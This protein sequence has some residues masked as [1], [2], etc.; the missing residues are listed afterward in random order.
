[1]ILSPSLTPCRITDV[2]LTLD[3]DTVTI[4]RHGKS[5]AFRIN[6]AAAY[7][8]QLCD[9]IKN[10]SQITGIVFELDTLPGDEVDRYVSDTISELFSRDLL[11][12]KSKD[13][14][15]FANIAFTD[16]QGELSH[17]DYFLANLMGEWFDLKVSPIDEA[18]IYVNAGNPGAF[19]EQAP[20]R[21]FVSE[22]G[23]VP[24]D[25][26]DFFFT[27]ERNA[28]IP[29]DKNLLLPVNA[30][31]DPVAKLLPEDYFKIVN[32]LGGHEDGHGSPPA[33]VSGPEA[34][35]GIIK[36]KLT[37][38]MATFDDY[39]GV[40]FSVQAIRMY[41]PEVTEETEILIIDNN[42]TGV[43][44]S[45][46]QN[47]S[48]Q[49]PGCRYL[50]VDDIRGTAVRDFVF[51]EASTDYVMCMDSHVFI[52]P[53]AI[54]K[55]IDY[56]D[57][58]PG[59]PDLLQGPLINDNLQEIN[60]HFEPAWREG[61]YGFW[62]CDER[63]VD[64]DGEAFDIPMQGLGLAAC[65][66]SAW[67]GYNPRFMGFGGEEGYIHQKFRNAGAR[68]LCLPFLRWMHR[69]SRP[70][71]VPYR[72]KWEDRIRNYLIGFEEVGLDDHLLQKHF[73]DVTSDTVVDA[74]MQQVKQERSSPFNFF[75]VI[76]C[77]NLDEQKGRWESMQERLE[78]LGILHRVKRFSAVKTPES[79]HIG[80][81]LSHR[82]IIEQAKKLGYRNI[83]VL[84]D[85]AL[86]HTDT[87]KYLANA[88]SELEN[89]DW[90]AF[91]L[92][93]MKWGEVHGEPYRKIENCRY[94]EHPVNLTCTHA[95]AY[96]SPFFNTL[97]QEVPAGYDEMK[98]WVEEH[99][100][101][102]QYLTK[103]DKMIVMD[104]VVATQQFI[105]DAEDETMRNG[106]R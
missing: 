52:V 81:T 83:L 106:F 19:K 9:G 17:L 79:S 63:G 102:D 86:F 48:E 71:G 6:N 50:A 44:A 45:A 35:G 10:I 24:N 11:G 40:Y 46:L 34:A 92:G 64:P 80:C 54:R 22:S 77:I 33:P 5:G 73:R 95:I 58:N 29:T 30:A 103:K 84:E 51:H 88:L 31:S 37:I 36:K 97:L 89:I 91:Y 72:N 60:T 25:D 68:T 32:V 16:Y 61:M 104:P 56:F 105:L 70:M 8:W 78:R 85:D 62:S 14:K 100:A 99:L 74:V 28:A 2:V 55:L 90:N 66:K 87:L 59:T 96:N 23:E 69:F 27:T 93:G 21:F 15:P 18:D 41:H 47:L 65:R 38:G 82:K 43:C 49:V 4:R 7:I 53:G 94:L 12:F 98:S 1:M 13:V 75:D 3:Q 20:L 26:Y 76:Y 39:D 101:I 57:Q 67:Q 42:P